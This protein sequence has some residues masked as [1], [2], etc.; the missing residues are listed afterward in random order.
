MSVIYLTVNSNLVSKFDEVD[1]VQW[2]EIIG[3]LGGYWVYV[4][5]AFGLFF[6][7][8]KGTNELVP[9][10]ILKKVFGTCCPSLK[11]DLPKL[12]QSTT[13]PDVEA[14]AVRTVAS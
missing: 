8:R 13:R 2:G 14:V 6:A 3:S 5:A 10:G 1:P 12:Q 11:A 9:S 4:G 7:I